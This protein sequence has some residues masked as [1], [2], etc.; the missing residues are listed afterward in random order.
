M[1]LNNGHHSI[2]LFQENIEND[3]KNAVNATIQ[4]SVKPC[5]K[6]LFFMRWEKER[7]TNSKNTRNKQ[8]NC[9]GYVLFILRTIKPMTQISK[10]NV[11]Q[12]GE[13]TE[14]CGKVVHVAG[15][16]NNRLTVV[17]MIMS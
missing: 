2:N 1:P 9:L 11:V 13:E 4:K 12:P 3:D 6:T 15:S 16:A 14:M 17:T 7:G 5:Y 8:D 10:T